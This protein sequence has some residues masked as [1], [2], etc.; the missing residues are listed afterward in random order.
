VPFYPSEVS[1]DVFWLK[2]E[3]TFNRT[4]TWWHFSLTIIGIG[5]LW[6]AF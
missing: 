2:D 3:S 6:L 5:V 1:L 4:A